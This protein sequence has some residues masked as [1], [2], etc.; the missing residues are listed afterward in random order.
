MTEAQLLTG[1]HLVHFDCA[2]CGPVEHATA[3]EIMG[4]VLVCW[5]CVCDLVMTGT[6]HNQGGCPCYPSRCPADGAVFNNADENDAHIRAF[7]RNVSD[8]EPRRRQ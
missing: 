8:D 1:H 6:R 2:V 7:H 3:V 5:G 4:E